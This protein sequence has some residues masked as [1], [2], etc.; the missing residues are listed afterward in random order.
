MTSQTPVDKRETVDRAIADHTDQYFNKTKRVI[1]HFGDKTVTYAVFMRRPV[2]FCPRLMLDWLNGM[3]Q[4]RGHSFQIEPCFEEG[5]WVGAGEPLVYITGSFHNLVDLETLY[6]QKLGSACV[7]AYNAYAMC[8]HM[9][10]TYFLAMDARHC[11]GSEMAELMAYAASVGS[12]AVVRELGALGFIGNANNATAHYF[13]N[14]FGMGTMPHALIGY[15]GSTVR[16]AEMFHESF[17]DDPLTVLV[18]YY[19]KEITDALATCRRFPDMA[20]AGRVSVRIDT[21]GGRFIEGLDPATSYAVLE[22]HMPRGIRQYR[23]EQELKWLVGTG[24]S[25]AAIYL[26]REQ[27]DEAGFDKVKIVASS[28]FSPEKCRTMGNMKAPIDVIGTGSFLPEIWPETY[29][30]A[31]IISYDGTPA[32]KLGR[33]FLLRKEKP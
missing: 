2:I 8:S 30:T 13:G 24:V 18:D 16:A 5:D 21:H 7:A 29:A 23:S 14:E 3:A 33:E 28:G 27:L 1:G 17:P 6:L 9:P 22:R 26:M 20:A 10:E 4:M 31:D 19:G 12:R 15:A 32:V 25:A 11:A